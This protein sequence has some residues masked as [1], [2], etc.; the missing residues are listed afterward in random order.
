MKSEGPDGTN[1]EI[2]LIIT[3]SDLFVRY[4]EK[5]DANFQNKNNLDCKFA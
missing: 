2:I 3:L 1:L 4:Q 5:T